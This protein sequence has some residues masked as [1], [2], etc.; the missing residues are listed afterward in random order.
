MIP[1]AIYDNIRH[2]A[3]NSYLLTA[4]GDSQ[5]WQGAKSLTYCKR[6]VFRGL[7]I[8]AKLYQSSAIK[9]EHYISHS[10]ISSIQVQKKS[11]KIP[12]VILKILLI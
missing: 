7:T 9:V 11:L 8:I 10:S 3:A 4:K 1:A 6:R 12:G 2:H 5:V